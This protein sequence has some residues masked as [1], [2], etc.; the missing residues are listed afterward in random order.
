MAAKLEE[1]GKEQAPSLSDLYLKYN[2]LTQEV[3]CSSCNIELLGFLYDD[4]YN[5]NLFLKIQELEVINSELESV[6]KNC[7]SDTLGKVE[8]IT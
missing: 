2:S 5:V 8:V 7:V 3:V 6:R 1:V 4:F